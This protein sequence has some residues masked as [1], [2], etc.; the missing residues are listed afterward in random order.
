MTAAEP[1]VRRAVSADAAAIARVHIASWRETY[2]RLL[3]PGALDDLDEAARASRWAE[4]V[5]D[6]VTEVHVAVLDGRIVGWCST[7]AGR[8][9]DAPRDLE[10]EGIYVL[11]E[12]HGSGAGQAL[13]DAG[14]GDRPAFLWSAEDNPRAQAFYRRNGFRDDGTRAEH[15]LHGHPV[16]I[17]RF[18]R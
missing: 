5:A 3:P 16:R 12:A 17:A 6:D 9:A 13:L 1:S 7:G 4:I 10:L 18:V 2:S 14:L 8:D 15:P 11:A